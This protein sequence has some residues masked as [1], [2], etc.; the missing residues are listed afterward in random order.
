MNHVTKWAEYQGFGGEEMV[1]A[2]N[3]LKDEGKI[4]VL[5]EFDGNGVDLVV[6]LV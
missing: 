5:V 2:L 6:E 1:S 4:K 3:Q